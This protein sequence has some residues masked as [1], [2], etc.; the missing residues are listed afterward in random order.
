MGRGPGLSE[1]CLGGRWVIATAGSPWPLAL[2]HPAPP[3]FLRCRYNLDPFKRHT[4][5]M[6]WRVLDRTFMTDTVSLGL[7]GVSLCDAC[8]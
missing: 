5:K 8:A 6:L 1:H 2:S 4:D 7:S 3:P